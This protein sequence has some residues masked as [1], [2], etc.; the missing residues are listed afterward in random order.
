MTGCRQGMRYISIPNDNKL[1]LVTYGVWRSLGQEKKQAVG[2]ALYN[3]G[4]QL[5]QEAQE[6][7]RQQR[8]SGKSAL[9][10][11]L[12]ELFGYGPRP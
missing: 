11:R 1:L 12:L 9:G 5:R 3:L 8:G 10:Y 4:A 6:R 7:E 2:S